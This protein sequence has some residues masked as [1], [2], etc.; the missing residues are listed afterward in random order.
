MRRR[1]AYFGGST[2]L[3]GTGEQNNDYGTSRYRDRNWLG[4][5]PLIG[6]P[7]GT[8]SR[9]GNT[10]SYRRYSIDFSMFGILFRSTRE[11][12]QLLNST[13]PQSGTQSLEN[14]RF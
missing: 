13:E 4:R 3:G 2:D 9:I 11:S 8:T 10:S 5:F 6:E 14:T 7:S 1:K 12:E